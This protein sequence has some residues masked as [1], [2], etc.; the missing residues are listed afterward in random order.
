MLEY[1]IL[2]CNYIHYLFTDLLCRLLLYG[3]GRLKLSEKPSMSLSQ[4]WVYSQQYHGLKS[5]LDLYSQQDHGSW[6][7]TWF[8]V[9][10]WTTG[11][12]RCY[13][14]SG[15]RQEWGNM[16]GPQRHKGKLQSWRRGHQE[17]RG[18]LGRRTAAL[19][20]LILQP[21]TIPLWNTKKKKLLF[22]A[23]KPPKKSLGLS[24]T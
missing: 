9:T 13:R 4:L 8:L 21:C 16:T 23:A 11:T 3:G 14:A 7:S 6:T 20:H 5:F 15:M 24:I 22:A 10:A 18:D 1:C 19:Y 17:C 12:S 2:K